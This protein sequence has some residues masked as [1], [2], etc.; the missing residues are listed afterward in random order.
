MLTHLT[1]ALDMM[2]G[3]Y[4]PRSSIPAAVSAVNKHANLTLLLCG[5]EKL[6]RERL[7]DLDSLNHPRLIIK[8]CSEVVTNSCEPA[9]AL[10]NKK[11][12]S[13]RVA[14]ELVKSG[15]AQACVSAGNTLIYIWKRSLYCDR[16]HAIQ[17]T[18][19]TCHVSDE[20]N[21]LFC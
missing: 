20:Y 11:S 5:S 10:R 9:S 1:I 18:H 4:G 7:S 16:G 2:G 14:L 19:W 17:V 15:E 12:S 3:D 21:F 8:H 13:M 6:I